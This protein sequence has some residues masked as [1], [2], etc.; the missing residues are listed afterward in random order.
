MSPSETSI[1]DNKLLLHTRAHLHDHGGV[2]DVHGELIR[3]PAEV[4]GAGVWV[5][6]AQHAEP[7]QGDTDI[8][9]QLQDVVVLVKDGDWHEG[10][11]NINQVSHA[12][13]MTTSCS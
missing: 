8:S 13:A 3:V 9:I 11:W 12:E 4:G 1:T 6:R 10:K 5:N 7:V 2:P